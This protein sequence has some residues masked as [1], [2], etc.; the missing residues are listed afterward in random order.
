MLHVSIDMTKEQRE[1]TLSYCSASGSDI[2]AY[3]P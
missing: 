3:E 1:T 2:T